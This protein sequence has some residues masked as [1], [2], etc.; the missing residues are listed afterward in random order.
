LSQKEN[1]DVVCSLEV[2]EH[3]ADVPQFIESLSSL[4]KPGGLLFMS[5]LNKNWI[6]YVLTI[7]VAEN[8]LRWCPPGTHDWKNYI[9][10]ENLRMILGRYGVVVNQM[11]GLQFNPFSTQNWIL[12]NDTTVNYFVFGT[13]KSPIKFYEQIPVKK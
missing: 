6:S 4:L 12:T 11:K 13:K 2:V 7:L 3:V 10:P 5:T 1:F 8:I 9:E